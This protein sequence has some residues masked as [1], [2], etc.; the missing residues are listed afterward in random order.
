MNKVPVPANT[1]P[2]WCYQIRGFLGDHIKEWRYILSKLKNPSITIIRGTG[3]SGKTGMAYYLMDMSAKMGKNNYMIGGKPDR[4]DHIEQIGAIKEVE[5]KTG[6]IT[7]LIDDIG[8]I[9]LTARS[10]ASKENRYLQELST[11]LS[12]KNISVIISVQNL[13]LLDV[14]GLMVSQDVLLISKISNSFSTKLERKWVQDE[15]RHANQYLKHLA[16][17]YYSVPSFD[18]EDHE[19]KGLFYDHTTS[20]T[21]YNPL[22]SYYSDDISKS[23]QEA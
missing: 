20:L 15:V 19:A 6:H 17:T 16:S 9:G 23:Y 21:G 3:R 10:H 5:S 8:A 13:R 14:K 7:L 22:P 18:S 2:S 11:V 12:H 4:V 1:V